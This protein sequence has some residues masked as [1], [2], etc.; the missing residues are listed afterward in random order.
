MSGMSAIALL[1][2][3]IERAFRETNYDERAFPEIA[4]RALADS[5]P[6]RAF[7]I[8]DLLLWAHSAAQIPSQPESDFGEPAVMLYCGRRFYIEALFWLDGTPTIHQ[9]GFSGA[10]QMLE[11]SSIHTRFR[12]AAERVVN[13]SLVLGA[14]ETETGRPEVLRKGDTRTIWA[15]DGLIHSTFHLDRPSVTLVARTYRD[16]DAAPQLRYLRSGVALSSVY[17]DS[18]LRRLL[19]LFEMVFRAKLPDRVPIVAGFLETGDLHS[20]ILVLERLCFA[21][22]SELMALAEVVA[23]RHVHAATWVRDTVD[24]VRRETLIIRRRSRVSAP[25][26]RFLLALLL[27]VESRDEVLRLIAEAVRDRDPIDQL[28]EWIAEMCSAG[29]GGSDD[30][31]L[32]YAL[33]EVELSVLRE[34]VRGSTVDEIVAALSLEYDDGA[35]Q[36]PAV[37]ALC[38]A[39]QN[40]ALFRS[41]L[42]RPDV[43]AAG[44]RRRSA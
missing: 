38:A 7:S 34:L 20:S 10:F 30:G 40:A 9:H 16:A 1:G 15:A 5:V 25:A 27:N 2:D 11:G 26:H 12:F 3:E 33:G 14:L 8:A 37:R 29:T 18:R 44:E 13:Q 4:S 39:L 32:D 6:H 36:A 41:I 19:E 35:D 42:R 31:G 43:G 22:R 23:R 17:D 24:C 21:E 28:V